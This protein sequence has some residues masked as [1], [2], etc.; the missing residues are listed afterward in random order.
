M[1]NF[2]THDFPNDL[3]ILDFDQLEKLVKNLTLANS[4]DKWSQRKDDEFKTQSDMLAEELTRRFNSSSSN[5]KVL[6][7]LSTYYK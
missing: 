6:S 7:L 3:T 4:G 5:I 2:C 1:V